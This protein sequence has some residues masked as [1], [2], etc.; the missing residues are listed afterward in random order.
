MADDR[1]A[2]GRDSNHDTIARKS[3]GI[4]ALPVVKMLGLTKME[5]EVEDRPISEKMNLNQMQI[6]GKLM[7]PGLMRQSYAWFCDLG[8]GKAQN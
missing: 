4:V 7:S 6:M 3:N 5:T 8:C 1:Q 2:S